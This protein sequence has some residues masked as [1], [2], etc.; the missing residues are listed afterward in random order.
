MFFFENTEKFQKVNYFSSFKVCLKVKL[1]F[2]LSYL[3]KNLMFSFLL[4][5]EINNFFCKNFFLNIFLKYIYKNITVNQLKISFCIRSPTHLLCLKS[6]QKRRLHANP[7]QQ[8]N[9]NAGKSS[10]VDLCFVSSLLNVSV[11]HSLQQQ[12][13]QQ[14]RKYS[15]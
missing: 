4:C 6:F 3:F 2:L 7:F 10:A 15:Q 5:S 12:Q 11:F 14:K 1:F 9:V 13:Q 8:L